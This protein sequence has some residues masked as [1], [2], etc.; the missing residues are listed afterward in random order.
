MRDALDILLEQL[1]KS[2]DT[3]SDKARYGVGYIEKKT[4]N[5]CGPYCY[6]RFRRN[7]IHHSFYLGK[8]R[9]LSI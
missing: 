6:L 5:N 9:E 3:G 7:G 8:E 2:E 1:E 4:I